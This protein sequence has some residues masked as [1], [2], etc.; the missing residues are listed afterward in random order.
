MGTGCCPSVPL[1]LIAFSLAL[2]PPPLL[3]FPS[4]V[5]SDGHF[6]A[7]PL[8]DRRNWQAIEDEEDDE[9]LRAANRA[10]YW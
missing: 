1:S 8:A 7:F 3:P 2:L 9:E 4:L 6:L 5:A 10:G